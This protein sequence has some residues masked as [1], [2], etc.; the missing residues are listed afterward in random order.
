MVTTNAMAVKTSTSGRSARAQLGGHAVAGQVARHDVEQAGHRRGAGEPEDQ[1]RADV[2]D[3][4]E[5]V[6]EQIVREEG[7]RAAVRLRRPPRTAAWGISRVVTRLLGISSTLMISAAVV[8]SLRV[9]RMRPP[10]FC[11]RVGRVA[12][13]QRHDDHAGL[14]AGE[15]EG[16]LREEQQGGPDHQ[17]AGCRGPASEPQSPVAEHVADAGRPRYRP[18]PI[19]TTFRAR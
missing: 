17:R 7:Q 19:T 3:R 5:A 16:Q 18:R 11:G 6:A 1:D 9:L 2:V 13:D 14:E 8:S 12:L 10:G 15:A 4:A